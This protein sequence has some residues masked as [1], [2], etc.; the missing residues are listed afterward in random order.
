MQEL[1]IKEVFNLFESFK[2]ETDIKLICSYELTQGDIEVAKKCAELRSMINELKQVDEFSQYKRANNQRIEFMAL[3]TETHFTSTLYKKHYRKNS[4]IEI[5]SPAIA[6]IFLDKSRE[7]F[8]LEYNNNKIEFDLKSQYYQCNTS[9]Q[10]INQKSHKRAKEKGSNYYVVALIKNKDDD[11]SDYANV[12]RIDYFLLPMS[13]VDEKS[14]AV[15]KS[16]SIFFDPYYKINISNFK[17][18]LKK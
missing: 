1:T 15:N 11:Y 3:L 17:D 9:S 12:E 6:S 13:F 4:K 18:K 16:T 14:I 10:N 8:V 2:T 5:K 7:D